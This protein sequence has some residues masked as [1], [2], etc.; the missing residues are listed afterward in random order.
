MLTQM[1]STGTC[2][3]NKNPKCESKE[4]KFVMLRKPNGESILVPVEDLLKMIQELSSKA[5]QSTDS[6][7][8]CPNN[9]CNSEPSPLDSDSSISSGA[10]SGVKMPFAESIKNGFNHLV[11]GGKKI[12]NNVKDWF[13]SQKRSSSNP[14]EDTFGNG[15]CGL[16]SLL[17][18]GKLFGKIGGSSGDA[19]SQIEALRK[20]SGASLNEFDGSTLPQLANGAR[21]IG[22]NA[23]VQTASINKLEAGLQRGEK[24]IAAV[25][26]EKLYPGLAKEGKHAIVILEINKD[27]GTA[28]IADP[29][30]TS[31]PKEVPLANL[32][33]AMSDMKNEVLSV[34][35]TKMS[36]LA[37]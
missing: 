13:V 9:N 3:A 6:F 18:M 26:P 24:F 29:S 7:T 16:A 34:S 22:L 4:P 14:N 2:S 27:K 1:S 15:N 11:D 10:D 23:N 37:A 31:G 5:N 30:D 35:D 8:P 28:I 12:F 36:S 21:K 17:M 32:S 19:D 20:I 33:S 25:N